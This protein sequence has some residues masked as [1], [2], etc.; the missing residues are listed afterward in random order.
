M[1]HGGTLHRTSIV[2]VENEWFMFLLMCF[3]SQIE[4]VSTGCFTIL[5]SIL[6][7][8]YELFGFSHQQV[9]IVANHNIFYLLDD[10]IT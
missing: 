10:L 8:Q 7:L 5:S 3:I 1:E 4:Q 9:R 2:R 6:C